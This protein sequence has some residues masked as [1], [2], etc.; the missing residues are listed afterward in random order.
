VHTEWFVEMYYD[1]RGDYARSMREDF[2]G[3]FQL[4]THWVARNYRNTALGLDLD[5]EPIAYGRK[6]H[7][8]PLTPDQ[9]RRIEI[10]R[11]NV[12]TVTRPGRDLIVACNFSFFIF[13]ERA[14]LLNYFR[15]A[16][17]SL[18]ARGM[19]ILEMA[20]G[21]GMLEKVREKK[22][23]AD[24]RGPAFTYTWEQKTFDPI[25]RLADYAIHFKPRGRPEIRDA[26]TYHWRLWTI[27]E[28]REAL[29]D[30]GFRDTRV[31]WEKSYRGEGTGEYDWRE[32]GDNAH[33]WVAYV[34]GLK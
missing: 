16:L 26:F 25:G 20:G 28:V 19:I 6:H 2:C 23:V 34:V 15:C 9:K 3:T 18:A 10:R 31:Y 27:P 33:S 8:A 4:S 17:K 29:R 22:V 24:G 11:A 12:L 1:L 21:P 7:L 14:T 30:A 5:P 32:R 13:L